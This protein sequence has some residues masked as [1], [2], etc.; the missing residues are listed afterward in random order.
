MAF[1]LWF[2]YLKFREMKILSLKRPLGAV[3]RLPE[4]PGV[5]L[6]LGLLVLLWPL[7][8]G[9]VRSS[10]ELA[11]GVDPNIYLYMMLSVMCFLGLLG[12]CWWLLAC[13]WAAFGLPAV[14]G[15][16]VHFKAMELWQQLSFYFVSFALL[17]LAAVG[18]LIAIC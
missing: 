7:A 14:N 3:M 10:D 17:L 16:V 12:M 15:L 1:M 6:V 4:I 8:Q 13:F 5:W 2:N 9:I 11:G 18:C